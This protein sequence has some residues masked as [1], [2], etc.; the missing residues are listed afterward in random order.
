MGYIP[1][2]PIPLSAVRPNDIFLLLG[3][4]ALWEL[5]VRFILFR[6]RAKPRKLIQKEV[7]LK[8][9]SSKVREYRSKGPSAFVECSKLERQLLA[10][11]KV[12]A[13]TTEKRKIALTKAEKGAKNA[14]IAVSALIFLL[15]YSIPILEFE[16]HRIA[17]LDEI[18]SEEEGQAMVESAH[19]AFLFPLSV[20]GIGLK[21]AKYGLANPQSTS[22]A[23]VAFWS[24]QT[25]VSKIFDAIDALN[26]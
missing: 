15:W 7:N 9:L 5:I 10:E 24:A 25:V 22:G 6:Y 12:M 23:L 4:G 8:A 20:V 16:A 17:K 2:P 19:K 11:E 13:D 18:F 14:N 21:I 1:H 26:V 3:L